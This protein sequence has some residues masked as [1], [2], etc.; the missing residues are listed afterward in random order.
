MEA[1]RAAVRRIPEPAL[2]L[3]PIFL[4]LALYRD[5]FHTWFLGDDFAWLSLSHLIARRHDLLYELF[6]PAA[7]GTI[8]PWSE[9]GFFILLESLFGLNQ[10]PFRIVAFATAAADCLLIAWTVKK[11]THSRLASVLAPV[12]WIANTALVRPLT[13]SSAY[14]ELMCPLFL[15]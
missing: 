12:L 1:F 13:W 2:W 9:R 10:V 15:L 4:L 6:A 7:Q 5:A 3:L 8:R 14:N 11:L